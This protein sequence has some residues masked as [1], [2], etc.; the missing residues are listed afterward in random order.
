MNY[1]WPKVDG[2]FCFM[3][4][5]RDLPGDFRIAWRIALII[6]ILG[7]CSVGKKASLRKLHALNWISHS[8]ENR[9]RFAAVANGASQ[10]DDLLIRIEPSL[11]RAIDFGVGEKLLE[12]VNGNR[13]KLTELGEK[14]LKKINS[15]PECMATERHFLR[16]IKSAATESNFNNLFLWKRAHN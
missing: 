1:T 15:G 12:W 5:P 16:S 10:P 7:E 4:R 8:K 2:P 9:D 14:V 11:N 13:V 3:R 6:L